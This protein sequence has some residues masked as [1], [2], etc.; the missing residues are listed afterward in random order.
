MWSFGVVGL[1]RLVTTWFGWMSSSPLL[2]DLFPF[3]FALDMARAYNYL[4]CR[5]CDL[6]VMLVVDRKEAP[7]KLRFVKDGF[8]SLS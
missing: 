1:L 7:W 2:D 6:R 5:R 4:L 8:V 3:E